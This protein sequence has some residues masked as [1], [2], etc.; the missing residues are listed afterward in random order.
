VSVN[1][2]CG[3]HV[4]VGKGRQNFPSDQETKNLFAILWIFENRLSRLHP[5]HRHDFEQCRSMRVLSPLAEKDLSPK[6]SLQRILACQSMAQVII[7]LTT[8]VVDGGM[9]YEGYNLLPGSA[10]P[11]KRTVEFRQHAGTLDP[12]AIINW[13]IVCV[14]LLQY[15]GEAPQA[16]LERFLWGNVEDERRFTAVDLIEKTAL[17]K[18]AQYYRSM[19]G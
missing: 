15:A 12:E 16:E 14:R 11:I 18:E 10:E 19:T 2:T 9:A 4:H 3:L 8:A 13:A 17:K 6:E 7:L 5:P 1:E